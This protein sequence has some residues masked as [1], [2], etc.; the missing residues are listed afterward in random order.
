[1]AS[2]LSIILLSYSIKNSDK[3]QMLSEC[4]HS[5]K[6]NTTDHELIIVDNGSTCEQS[7]DLMRSSADVYIR[8][9]DNL[10]FGPGMN[11][12]YRVAKGEFVCFLNDDIVLPQGWADCLIES[13][14]EGVSHPGLWPFDTM[15]DPVDGKIER[16]N[17]HQESRKEIGVTQ[18]GGFG[19]CFVA[20]KS[21]FD[22]VLEDGK[23]FDEQFRIAMFEDTDLWKRMGK[24]ERPI[25][26]DNRA[27][28]YHVGNGTVGKIMEF[29]EAYK[30]N[31]AKYKAK[32]GL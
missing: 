27:Y 16:L 9:K 32:W 28:V 29:H 15:D 26:C 23:V 25:V 12:G 3:Y 8:L 10:G 24:A 6:K 20:R 1:M 19:A 4:I 7:V 30:E 17:A 18:S 5:I 22:A 2:R 31:E 11:I 21:T 14:G 13:C